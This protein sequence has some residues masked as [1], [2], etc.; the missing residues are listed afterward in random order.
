MSTAPAPESSNAAA[1]KR[2]LRRTAAQRI[3]K[4]ERALERERERRAVVSE[5][6][7][8]VRAEVRRLRAALA[9]SDAGRIEA[10]KAQL[11][12]AREEIAAWR[13][14]RR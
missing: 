2:P 3:A 4:A 8:L 11:D 12:R 5:E 9:R 14:G 13:S 6:L 1:G 7:R 10:L